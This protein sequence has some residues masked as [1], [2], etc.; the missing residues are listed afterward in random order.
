[1]KIE[2]S[3]ATSKKT[4][5]VVKANSFWKKAIGLAYKNTVPED[6]MLFHF[7][8]PCQP[9]FWMWGMRFDIDLI[10]LVDNKVV[11]WFDSLPHP[12]S[13]L[14]ILFPL[15]LKLYKPHTDITTAL[16]IEAGKRKEWRIDEN[17]KIKILSD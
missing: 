7:K 17:S 15:T 1:M 6:G 10:W 12:K 16:E 8:K 14:T 13:F 3:N 9:A 4:L 5:E 11:G 2:I